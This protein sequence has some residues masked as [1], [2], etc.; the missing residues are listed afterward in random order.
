VLEQFRARYFDFTT[1]HFQEAI[2]WR[3][4]PSNL[5]R[6]SALTKARP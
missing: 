6:N 3:D 4:A 1:E 2:H 5:Q